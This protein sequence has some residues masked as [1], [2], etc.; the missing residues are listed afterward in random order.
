MKYTHKDGTPYSKEQF[1]QKLKTDKEFSDEF[2][3]K[4]IDQIS[5]LIRLLKESPDSR[6]L[7]VSAWNPADL[8]NQVLP[9]CHYGFQVYTRELSLEERVEIYGVEK[10]QTNNAGWYECSLAEL[11]VN[12]A[13]IPKRAISL[14]YNA[15][16]QDVPLGTPFNISSYALLLTIIAKEVNMVPDE[17]ITNMGD[18]HIYLNQIDGVKEQLTREPYPLPKLLCLD[19]FHYL[20]DKEL[21][22]EI[23][24]SEKIE[25]FRPDFFTLENYQSHPSIKIPLSN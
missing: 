3:S 1:L 16:S 9:P 22:G 12:Q 14:M 13:N 2:G 4:G 8:P 10:I 18:C 5:E 21:V 25:K 24:F 6:R 7:L 17:L 23:P 20:M 19:E 15:R 11:D